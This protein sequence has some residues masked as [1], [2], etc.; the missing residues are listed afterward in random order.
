MKKQEHPHSCR[1]AARGAPSARSALAADGRT[2]RK[3]ARST[4]SPTSGRRISFDRHKQLVHEFRHGSHRVAR[5]AKAAILTA[6]TASSSSARHVRDVG[7]G[8]EKLIVTNAFRRRAIRRSS[9][10]CTTPAPTPA[11]SAR[12]WNGRASWKFLVDAETAPGCRRTM[13]VTLSAYD[14]RRSICAT[15]PRRA[16]A[17]GQHLGERLLR[18]P[19]M[20]RPQ[21]R[22][23]DGYIELLAR[24]EFQNELRQPQDRRR[25]PHGR[26][27]AL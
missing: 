25:V 24:G 26:L 5:E 22:Q 1:G 11:P 13:P 10:C 4:F 19:R 8:D 2:A 23:R 12:C 27:R 17:V 15:T 18:P 9:A 6:R 21:L 20:Q 16:A 14:I 7:Y 3:A